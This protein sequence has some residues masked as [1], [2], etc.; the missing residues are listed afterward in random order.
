V[1]G[2]FPTIREAMRQRGW[3]EKEE[4]R[5]KATMSLDDGEIFF[6]YNKKYQVY[7]SLQLSM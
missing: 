3:I 6:H 1:Q 2:T 4:N 5:N 7:T